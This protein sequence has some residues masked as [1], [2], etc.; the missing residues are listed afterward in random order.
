VVH[1]VGAD[2][3]K[4]AELGLEDIVKTLEKAGF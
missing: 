1:I 3:K 4:L 2:Q